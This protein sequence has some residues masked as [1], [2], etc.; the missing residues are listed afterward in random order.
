MIAVSFQNSQ[1]HFMLDSGSNINSLCADIYEKYS[2]HLNIIETNSYY[3]ID[4]NKHSAKVVDFTF[5]VEKEIYHAPFS[6]LESP[7]GFDSVEKEYDI[8]ING[9]IGSRFFM[10]N[11]WV[12]DFSRC[13]VFSVPQLILL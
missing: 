7:N 5:S 11:H 4:G 12:L 8:K 9:V 10:D 3:G 2:K 1:L 13:L 6:I